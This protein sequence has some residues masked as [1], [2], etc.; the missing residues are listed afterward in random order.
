M[1]GGTTADA[2]PELREHQ[3][4]MAEAAEKA[5]EAWAGGPVAEAEGLRPALNRWHREKD[6]PKL[7]RQAADAL[8]DAAETFL[9]PSSAHAQDHDVPVAQRSAGVALALAVQRLRLVR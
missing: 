3:D 6:S 7:R 8:Q 4:V 1:S 2:S 9:H 5:A